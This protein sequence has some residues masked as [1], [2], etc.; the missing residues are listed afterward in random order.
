MP[1]HKKRNERA[2]GREIRA[3]GS[4]P[5]LLAVGHS[6]RLSSSSAGGPLDGTDGGGLRRISGARGRGGGLPWAQQTTS[7][8]TPRAHG[9]ATGVSRKHMFSAAA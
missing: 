7:L 6:S 5:G 4:A 3:P 9:F 8:G 2:G 1:S